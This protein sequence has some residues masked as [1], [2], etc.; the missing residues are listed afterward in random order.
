MDGVE[1]ETVLYD[2]DYLDYKFHPAKGFQINE[3]SPEDI[4]VLDVIISEV[5][6]LNAQEIIEKMHDEDAYK[7]TG[8]YC[9]I[10]FSYANKFLIR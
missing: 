1:Y 8:R 2:K 10:P 3:L 9:V 4:E 6:D 5:G 7:C